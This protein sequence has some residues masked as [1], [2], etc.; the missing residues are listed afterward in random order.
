MAERE[1][2]EVMTCKCGQKF[3][4]PSQDEL[5]LHL[6]MVHPMEVLSMPKVQVAI[7]ENAYRAGQA[8]ADFLRG[9]NGKK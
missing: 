4:A 2:S 8:F 5:L 7:M 6:I 1:V 9:A 3:T